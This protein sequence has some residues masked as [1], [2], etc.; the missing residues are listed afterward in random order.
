LQRA[1]RGVLSNDSDPAGLTL[2]AVLTSGPAHGALTLNA[3]GAFTYTP[4][5]GFSGSDSF[6]YYATNGT[7]SSSQTSVT[8]DVGTL[9]VA[10]A[11]SY[12]VVHDRTTAL[13][14]LAN[15]TS[16]QGDYPTAYVTSLPHHGYVLS[17]PND[18]FLYTPASGYTGPDS[19]A[20]LIVDPF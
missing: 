9:P 14:V 2:S 10:H 7:A 1:A 5:T 4:S 17:G 15:D 6:S 8:L 11:D 20:Y 12:N 18:T 3:N 19:F 16:P 13:A